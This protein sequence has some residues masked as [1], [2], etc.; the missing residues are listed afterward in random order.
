MG[1]ICAEERKPP[2]VEPEKVFE[3]PERSGHAQGARGYIDPLD[4]D[5]PY[6]PDSSCDLGDFENLNIYNKGPNKM[7]GITASTSAMT[8]PQPMN[9]SVISDIVPEETEYEMYQDREQTLDL[10]YNPF[11]QKPNNPPVS[12]IL[13]SRKV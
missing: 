8:H 10:T 4:A 12:S 7:S 2:K 5:N 9:M 6:G 3:F 11:F 13:M 1:N